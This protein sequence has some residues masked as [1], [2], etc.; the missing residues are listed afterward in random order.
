M[1]RPRLERGAV[2]VAAVDLSEASESVFEAALETA[3]DA[4]DA[5][6]HLVHVV[7]T[8][9]GAPREDAVEA[10]AAWAEQL[11]AHAARIDLHAIEGSNPAAA[12]VGFAAQVDADAI[13]IGTHGRGGVARALQRS[14]AEAVVRTATCSVFVVRAKQEARV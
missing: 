4:P 6:I 13:L 12:I 3:H 11:P 1:V 14:V 2:V 7:G 10:L 9:R 8:R 5:T